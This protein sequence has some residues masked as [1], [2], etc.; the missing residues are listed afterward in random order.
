M[1]RITICTVACSLVLTTAAAAPRLT[2]QPQQR[3]AGPSVVYSTLMGGAVGNFDIISD[4]AV[5]GDGNAY[6]VG[7]TGSSDFPTKNALQPALKGDF[8][9]FVAKFG[10][11]GTLVYSTFFGGTGNESGDAIAVDAA[12][13]VF[14][15]GTTALGGFPV[16]NAFQPTP[17]GSGDAF[18]AKIASD[19]RSIEFASYLGGNQ[20]EEVAD[21][22]LD[23]FGGIYVAGTV[24][25]RGAASVTFPAVNPIQESYGGGDT[26][27]FASFIAPDGATLAFST[28]FDAGVQGG[29]GAGTDR[30]SSI[31]VNSGNGDVFLAG[32]L[33]LNQDDPE[34]LVIGRFRLVTGRT[35]TN[36]TR[37]P[38]QI[39]QYVEQL[40]TAGDLTLPEEFAA[41]IVLG[42][43]FGN[44]FADG[45][46]PRKERIAG[47]TADIRV[48]VEGLCHPASPGAGCDEPAAV[49]V[50]DSD[51]HFK[52]AENLPLLRQFFVDA[53]TQDA[54]GA[55]Y[56]AGDISSDRLTTVDP[57]QGYGGLNDGVIAVIAPGASSPAF[58]TFFGG[59]GFDVPTAIAVDADGNIYVAG[60][61]TRSTTFPTTP[62]A[63]QTTPKG[64]DDGFLVKLSRVPI[65]DFSVS[66][67][68]ETVTV[69]RGSKITVPIEIER[70]GGFAGRVTVTSPATVPGI[71]LPKKPVSTTAGVANLKIKVKGNAP[72]GPQQFTFTAR[73]E[74]GRTRTATLTL[75]VE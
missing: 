75:T 69:A 37:A 5:D 21:L 66:F 53:V 32:N 23:T 3:G 29:I 8:D 73:D 64:L 39:Y 27:A 65:P 49:A 51:L 35:E 15:A 17:G 50:L 7:T 60:L 62:G 10:P 1:R 48:L 14:L 44:L 31:G 54:Q 30:I 42:Y 59:D 18:V 12:G 71:K 20:S 70:L 4:L 52:R 38:V 34:E 22:A 57:V 45:P 16:K 33:E 28:L 68:P 24:F 2:P 58:A 36:R 72:V 11:D 41:K 55:V 9:A 46:Q 47:G 67:D 56:I 74:S 6:I 40:G 63:L 43:L 13:A 61:T 25:G 19:G 26:D